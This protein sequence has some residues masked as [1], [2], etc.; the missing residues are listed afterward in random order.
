MTEPV[1]RRSGG[2]PQLPGAA[3]IGPLPDRSRG[4]RGRGRLRQFA[5][6]SVPVLS[7]SLLAFVPFLRLAFARSRRRSQARQIARANRVLAREL[8]IGRPDLPREY[9][10][11]G[12]VDVNHVPGDILTSCLGL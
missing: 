9:D 6:A 4:S 11:G 3:P 2:D 10:D 12:L 7:L 5:W 1:A 8:R